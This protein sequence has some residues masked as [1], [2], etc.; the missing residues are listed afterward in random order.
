[1]GRLIQIFDKVRKMPRHVDERM[2]RYV[3]SMRNEGLGFIRLIV[4]C[5]CT[6]QG[7]YSKVSGVPKIAVYLRKYED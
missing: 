3:E 5:V 1:M 2:K 4:H 6:S 7:R